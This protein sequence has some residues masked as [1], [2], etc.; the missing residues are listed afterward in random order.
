MSVIGPPSIAI[1]AQ[2]RGEI[3]EFLLPLILLW[4]VLTMFLVD[5]SYSLFHLEVLAGFCALAIAGAV[6]GLSGLLRNKIWYGLAMGGLFTWS[7]DYQF[8]WVSELNRYLLLVLFIV[9]V[10]VVWKLTKNGH[11]ILRAVLATA[12]I[13]SVVMSLIKMIHK[14]LIQFNGERNSHASSPRLIHLIFDEHIGIDGLPSEF[15]P[16]RKAR[17]ELAEF[18]RE[19]GFAL[20][21]GA[22]SRYYETADSIPNLLN[23]TTASK[24]EALVSGTAD[25]SSFQISSNRYFPLLADR[26]YHVSVLDTTYLKLCPDLP[27]PDITCGRYGFH[28]L[29]TL[30]DLRLPVSEKITAL[31]S[32]FVTRYARYRRAVLAYNGRIR[33]MLVAH[34]IPLPR[35]PV[36]SVWTLHRVRGISVN[37]MAMLDEL[38]NTIG[39]MPSGQALVAHVMLPHFPYA[40]YGD[41][42]LRPIHDWKWGDMGD[43]DEVR[44]PEWRAERYEAYLEQLQCLYRKL[45]DLFAHLKEAG[46]FEDSIIIAHG[47]H[48]SR[49]SIH[50]PSL[51]NLDAMTHADYLD[52]FSTL[53]AVKHSRFP[54]GRDS[55]P[56]ALDE[57]LL[58]ALG[59]GDAPGAAP[60]LTVTP[61][62][63]FF[64]AKETPELFRMPY[65]VRPITP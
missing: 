31:F 49:F 51:N 10:L 9:V 23:F 11:A 61:P 20:Y 65:P 44:T 35:L 14:P 27:P 32:A 4:T 37:A 42:S 6:V 56:R 13:A 39:H 52:S 29:G 62:S 25:R 47:D 28:E 16:G 57:L 34:G 40:Y 45:G 3:H 18:Y 60:S 46:L 24:A 58:A 21:S 43:L 55:T 53:F 15:A 36:D 41:C 2:A 63:V 64:S 22:Y 48:G 19:H 38:T 59:I 54:P 1:T 50:H 5:Q 17:A 8:N 30:G 12:L 33:P 26:L 7:L